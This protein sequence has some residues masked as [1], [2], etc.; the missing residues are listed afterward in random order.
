MKKTVFVLALCLMVCMILPMTLFGG[1]SRDRASN[2]G[3]NVIYIMR[4]F[5]NPWNLTVQAGARLAAERYNVN[6]TFLAPLVADSNEEMIQLTET[7]LISGR[8]NGYVLLSLD[9]FTMIPSVRKVHEAGVPVV[10]TAT[11]LVYDN[12]ADD[13][14]ST[15]IISSNPVI[16]R[17]LG[18][19]MGER[20]NGRGDVIVIGGPAGNITSANRV[21]GTI[22]GL[23]EFPG[24]RVVAEQPGDWRRDRS[25][26]VMQNLLQTFPNVNAVVAMNDEMALGAY[27]AITA[28]GRAGQILVS[29]VDANFDALQAVRDGQLAFTLDNGPYQIGYEAIKA[30]AMIFDG[31]PVPE[32][33]VADFTIVEL[34]NIDEYTAS[35]ASRNR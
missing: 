21:R 20:L 15:T 3:R 9:S 13:V 12:P 23:Q 32:E 18:R 28:A 1:G 34:S 35:I 8:M 33:I 4:N 7:A 19:A 27:E 25:M 14:A 26:E 22:E 16:G 31:Q 2:D 10:I 30:L 5:I 29:G 11:P 6:V 17:A 24:I